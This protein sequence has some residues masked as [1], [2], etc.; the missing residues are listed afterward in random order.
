MRDRT[1]IDPFLDS[2]DAIL[3]WFSTE[4]KQTL[5]H[6]VILKQ[7]MIRIHWLRVMDRCFPSFVSM[8]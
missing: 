2:I 3:A 4:L 5:S 1:F 6:T 7:L 8:G